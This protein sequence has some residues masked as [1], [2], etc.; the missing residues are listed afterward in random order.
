MAARCDRVVLAMTDLLHAL[1]RDI[2]RIV[3]RRASTRVRI[4]WK[5]SASLRSGVTKARLVPASSSAAPIYNARPCRWSRVRLVVDAEASLA[6][7]T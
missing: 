6:V 2:P 5:T 1:D 3:S 4:L 7:T